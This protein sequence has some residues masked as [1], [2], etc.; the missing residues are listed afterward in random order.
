[1]ATGYSSLSYLKRL[2]IDFVKLD[3]SFVSG[4][5]TDPKDAAL[6]MA[7]ITLAHNLDLK[8]VAEGV[9]TEEQRDFLR[10]LRCDAGQGYLFGKPMPAAVF[11]ATISG[12]PPRKRNALISSGPRKSKVS[13]RIEIAR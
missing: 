3:R 4:A 5:T 1:L 13:Q 8:V 11:E 9:E 2:P 12:N 7:I 10:L 6:V